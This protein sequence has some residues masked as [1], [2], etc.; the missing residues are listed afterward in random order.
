V[1]GLG[2]SRADV[3]RCCPDVPV[4]LAW[5]VDGGRLVHIP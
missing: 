3:P 1:T 2:Y 5:R 4:K